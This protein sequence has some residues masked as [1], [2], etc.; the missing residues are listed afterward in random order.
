M[1]TL[2]V[3]LAL[4]IAASAQV[5]IVASQPTL[6]PQCVCLSPGSPS[7]KCA[8]C[9]CHKTAKPVVSVV[10]P[11]VKQSLTTPSYPVIPD[12][13]PNRTCFQA[14]KPS[15]KANVS[16]GP[17]VSPASGPCSSCSRGPVR[18][19]IAA[20]PIRRFLFRRWR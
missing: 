6:A 7:C 20:Q 4:S 12:N 5:L 9:N 8:V 15:S 1:K 14:P 17:A 13:C 18:S 16:S 3:I 10:K 11:V 19:V 2:L